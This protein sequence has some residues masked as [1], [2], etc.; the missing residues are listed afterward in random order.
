[1]CFYLFVKLDLHTYGSTWGTFSHKNLNNMVNMPICLVLDHQRDTL[2]NKNYHFG[3][4]RHLNI[5]WRRVS[6]VLLSAMVARIHWLGSTWKIRLKV[7]VLD[8]YNGISLKIPWRL[9]LELDEPKAWTVELCFFQEW[10]AAS[11]KNENIDY[12][13]N[14]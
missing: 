8:K 3:N 1:M 6:C 9:V 11:S 10:P 4:K 7:S 13:C 12:L 14:N 5:A 2:D